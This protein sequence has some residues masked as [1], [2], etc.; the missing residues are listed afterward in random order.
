MQRLQPAAPTNSR[1]A[2]FLICPLSQ[3]TKAAGLQHFCFF[4]PKDLSA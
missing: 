4:R 1:A 3:K 2:V